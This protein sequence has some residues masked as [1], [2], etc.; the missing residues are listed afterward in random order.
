MGSIPGDRGQ[1][2][3]YAMNRYQIH[4]VDVNIMLQAGAKNNNNKGNEP[5]KEI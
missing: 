4:T 1:E 2:L 5:G 3:K